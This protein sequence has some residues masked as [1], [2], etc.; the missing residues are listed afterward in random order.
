MLRL[1]DISS[2]DL[3]S[4]E[5]QCFLD[6]GINGVY[7]G[8]YSSW[9]APVQMAMAAKMLQDAGVMIWAFYGLPYFGDAWGE[10]R[11]LDWAITLC[12][13]FGITRVVIDA[14]TDANQQGWDS[15]P[16]PT[17]QQR[18]AVIRALVLKIRAAGLQP[19][20]Y[21]FTSWWVI[22]HENTTEFRD[23]PLILANYANNDGTE[24]VVTTVDFG[25]WTKIAGHQYTSEWGLVNGCGRDNRDANVIYEEDDHMQANEM[26]LLL[27]TATLVAGTSDGADFG[28]VDE[29]LAVIRPLV[30]NDIIELLGIN[31]LNAEI[32]ALQ[33]A[34]AAL[35]VGNAD[36]DAIANVF[37]QAAGAVRMIGKAKANPPIVMP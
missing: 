3:S 7:V 10:N 29:A 26:E 20:I 33:D 24:H 12:K 9:N 18:N 32:K 1:L 16:T 5:P 27:K 4:L 37:Q 34:L 11:D 21:T 17:P 35:T 2:N 22:Q 14:E 8:T 19:Y 13:Q 6:H 30:Q 31:N 15:A 23:V 25:G 36:Y 28:T